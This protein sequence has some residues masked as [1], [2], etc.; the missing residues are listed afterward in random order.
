M[1]RL[2]VIMTMVLPQGSCSVLPQRSASTNFPDF[3]FFFR[4]QSFPWARPGEENLRPHDDP[5]APPDGHAL[6]LF[7]PPPEIFEGPCDAGA[8]AKNRSI[9]RYDIPKRVAWFESVGHEI[10]LRTGRIPLACECG[11]QD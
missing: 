11:E 1:I 6:A 3:F 2:C 4:I 5:P 8:P 7:S 9:L 10:N